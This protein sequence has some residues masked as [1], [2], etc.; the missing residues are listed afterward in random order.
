MYPISNAVKALFE[1]DQAKV[2]RITGTDANGA[3]ISITDNDVLAGSFQIDRYACNLEKLEIGTAVAAQMS[4]RLYNANGAFDGIVFEGAELFAEVGIADWSLSSPTVTYIPCGYF[5][6]DEQPKKLATIR[7]VCLDRMT[8]FDAVAE[9]AALTFPDT[10]AGLVGQVCTLRGVTLA[11]TLTG[12]PNADVQIT[13]LPEVQGYITY[14]NLIQW[15]AGLMAT[16]A[17][18]DWNGELRFSWYDGAQTGYV[19]TIDNRYDSDY[20]AAL[21]VTGVSYT[22]DSGV[23]VLS[24]T[25]DYAL[26][27]TGNALAGPL[28]A[29]VLPAIYAAVNGFSYRPFSASAISAPYLWPMDAVMFEDMDGNQTGSALTNVCFGLNGTTSLVSKGLSAALN[30]MKL[31]AGV[32]KE[33]AQIIGNVAESVTALDEGLDQQEIFNRLTDNGAAQGIILSNGQLYINASYIQSGTLTLG[34]QNNGNGVLR[35]L[36]ANG[37]QIG[38]WNNSGLAIKGF[39]NQSAITVTLPE[40]Y[41]DSGVIQ[42]GSTSTPFYFRL[43]NSVTNIDRRMG[44]NYNGLYVRDSHD[45]NRAEVRSYGL[46]VTRWN[47]DNNQPY[48]TITLQDDVDLKLLEISANSGIKFYK[49]TDDGQGNIGWALRSYLLDNAYIYGSLNVGD[50]ATTRSNL[51][52]YLVLTS[53]TASVLYNTLAG[54]SN[55]ETICAVLGRYATQV[56]IADSSIDLLL[57]GT[58]F[59]ISSSQFRFSMSSQSGAY[60]YEWTSTYSNGAWTRDTGYRYDGT[61]L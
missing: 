55:S 56:L 38:L 2:L 34:G 41:N 12:L 59:K 17:W 53:S 23:T 36:D 22:N 25:D 28:V 18:M 8:K 39:P 16:N 37:T 57:M 33:Q 42:L 27:L 24:G 52:T 5:T 30:D 21:T 4:L 60:R 50:A 15:C 26:D 7:L 44:F 9:P 49:G 29:T 31:P 6:P 45:N 1:A 47:S 11:T 19:S 48:P 40:V 32:T 14:R 43:E 58:I 61:A 54:L 10:V 20:D 51:G 13:G 35:V 46:H 3:T